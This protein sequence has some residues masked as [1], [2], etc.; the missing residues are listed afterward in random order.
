MSSVVAQ[1]FLYNL[2]HALSVALSLNL[3]LSNAFGIGPNAYATKVLTLPALRGFQFP[4][5]SFPATSIPAIKSLIARSNCLH[6]ITED[7]EHST[8]YYRSRFPDINALAVNGVD[9]FYEEED[10]ED[11]DLGTGTDTESDYG[12]SDEKDSE[13]GEIVGQLK[14]QLYL[15]YRAQIFNYVLPSE[16]HLAQGRRVG[17][18]DY[19]NAQRI[20]AGASQSKS[21][22]TNATL[23]GLDGSGE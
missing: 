1:L 15:V 11:S 18:V 8:H 20:P 14:L 17:F 22:K 19:L 2:L 7:A 10:V 13:D 23:I 12:S 21:E 3:V 5:A 6:I 9:A 16:S 4:E